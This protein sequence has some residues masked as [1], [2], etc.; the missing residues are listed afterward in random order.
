MLSDDIYNIYKL[1]MQ[2][3]YSIHPDNSIASGVGS[4]FGTAG[5]NYPQAMA[6][7]A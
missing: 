1:F 6:E 2:I 3:M 5:A 7:I 4:L